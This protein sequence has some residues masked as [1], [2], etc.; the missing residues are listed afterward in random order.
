M[1]SPVTTVGP[2]SVPVPPEV[3]KIEAKPWIRMALHAFGILL[4]LIIYGVIQE[5]I[6][7]RP[8]ET[9]NPD[10]S[11]GEPEFFHISAYLVLSNRCVAILIAVFMIWYRGESYKNQ[12]PLANCAGISLSNTIATYCQYEAL[13]YVSF[14]TQTLG[15]CGKMIPVMILGIFFTGK[16]YGWKD[17]SIAA[18]VTVGCVLFVLSGTISSSTKSDSVYGLAL[19]GGYLFSDGFTSTFQEYL[20]RGYS[21]STYNQMLY[22]NFFSGL[23]SLLTLIVSGELLPALE[24]S[25]IHVDFFVGS[26]IL[27]VSAAFGQL[28]ILWT[29]K[30]FGALFFATVMTLR[31]IFSI[32]ISCLIYLHPLTIGQWL[33]S[34]I[35]FGALYYKDTVM[36]SA[37]KH[38]PA[39][40]EAK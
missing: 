37:H 19:M 27:S 6:M 3:E 21:M 29:I 38:A 18:V 4:S 10:G 15:K 30:E 22:V 17:F 14:P 34:L 28:V 25:A 36:R 26:L 13:K 1:S 12:A 16:K 9:I 8:Y 7:T 11:T 35:V 23:V 20:F 40:T 32:V 39:K 2:V 5:R 33:S 24:F 31:Q